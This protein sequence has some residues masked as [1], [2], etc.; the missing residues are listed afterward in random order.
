MN[1]FRRTWVLFLIILLLL[2]LLLVVFIFFWRHLPPDVTDLWTKPENRTSFLIS[3]ASSL[4]FAVGASLFVLFRR[5][6]PRLTKA[7]FLR[8]R[9]IEDESVEQEK[10]YLENLI[11]LFQSRGAYPW[12]VNKYIDLEATRED[13]EPQAYRVQ[14]RLWN[15][16]EEEESGS[17]GTVRSRVKVSSFLR[18][19]KGPILLKGEPGTGKTHAIRRF[20]VDQAE[21]ARK[22]LPSK[23]TIPIYV[24][25]GSY[26]GK[27]EN[28][29]PEEVS[30]FLQHYLQEKYPWSGFLCDHL[31]EYLK[32]GRLLLLFDGLNELPLDEY[33]PRLNKLE[34]FV[35]RYPK[36]KAIFTC[37]TL[38][39]TSQSFNTIEI[40]DLSDTL[41][42]PFIAQYS[43]EIDPGVIDREL[44]SGDR[45]MLRICHNPFMLRMLVLVRRKKT[46]SPQSLAG[47]FKD[48]VDNQLDSALFKE[49]EHDQFAP[50]SQ[51]VERIADVLSNIAFAMQ[52]DGKFAGD[53][54][55][56]WLQAEF[57]GVSLEEHLE[58]AHEAKLIDYTPERKCKFAHQILQ[59][60]FAAVALKNAWQE[61]KSLETYITDYRWGDTILVCAGIVEETE[62]FIREIWSPG[63]T[64]PEAFWLATKAVGSSNW[65]SV[66]DTY[67]ESL[68]EEAK[69]NLG[70]SGRAEVIGYSRTVLAVDTVK[71]LAYLDDDRTAELLKEVLVARGSWL[72]E[73]CIQT[74]GTSRN[75][76]A[77]SLLHSTI[78]NHLLPLSDVFLAAPFFSR[79]EWLGILA[80]NIFS[81]KRPEYILSVLTGKDRWLDSWLDALFWVVVICLPFLLLALLVRNHLFNVDFTAVSGRLL[82]LF[83]FL[84]LLRYYFRAVSRLP[85]GKE[86]TKAKVKALGRE[87]TWIDPLL[88]I[89]IVGLLIFPIETLLLLE[90]IA[91]YTWLILFVVAIILRIKNPRRIASLLYGRKGE[92]LILSCIILFWGKMQPAVENVTLSNGAGPAP[93]SPESILHQVLYLIVWPPLYRVSLVLMLLA[94]VACAIVYFITIIVYWRLRQYR[95]T[96]LHSGKPEIAAHIKGIALNTAWWTQIRKRACKELRLIELSSQDI[97]DFENLIKTEKDPDFQREL[98]RTVYELQARAREK[99]REGKILD[100]KALDKKNARNLANQGLDYRRMKLYQ[101]AIAAFDQAI[102]INERDV[103]FITERGI[104]YWEMKQ[105]QKALD[106]FNRAI[107]LDEKD[108][109]ALLCQAWTHWEMERYQEAVADFT[110]AIALDEKNVMII[111]WRGQVYREMGHYQEALTDFSLAISISKKYIPAIGWR[112]S[113]YR[114][115]KRYQEALDDF[116]RIIALNEK[117]SWSFAHRGMIYLLTG[118]YQ[119]ALND[120]N[121]AISLNEESYWYRYCRALVYLATGKANEFENE[122]NSAIVLLQARLDKATEDQRTSLSFDLALFNLVSGNTT[123][124][125]SQYG[126]L[127][128]NCSSWSLL[129]TAVDDLNDFLVVQSSDQVALH[130]RVQLETRIAELK[131]VSAQ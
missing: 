130:V 90:F 63:R 69:K 59:E 43:G 67:H 73:L 125:E 58:V 105:Y 79:R 31:N 23:V 50:V 110:R 78:V 60:Y 97:E 77:R 126:Q 30:D 96:Y 33:L 40:R 74:L 48:Y 57:P 119:E 81:L 118:R 101:E 106:D 107:L 124:A 82:A 114:K 42:K 9:S 46:L 8:G 16:A 39:Y 12:E 1:S 75:D 123:G 66:S 71:A 80:R 18:R 55:R 116:T 13:L 108:V 32:Q 76:H 112:A 26:I 129:Q 85:S 91:L 83:V 21:D 84:L 6:I 24:F 120:F 28:D 11:E 103:E 62:K 128:A 113:T 14:P 22:T 36:N 29:E 127:A 117:E 19:E 93:L 70:L 10:Q 122:L 89:P 115:I 49:H 34:E 5:A 98:E 17:E 102:S 53:V 4:V 99:D 51:N 47:L 45:F 65:R 3:I 121:Q 64:Y 2:T 27:T 92:T 95:V 88:F 131:K 20:A 104:T 54:T 52:K 61:G 100:K 44:K 94:L 86:S 68:I 15:L 41:I 111:T 25:L 38:R 109:Q 56:E 35:L 37:R 72:R 87:F 7:V